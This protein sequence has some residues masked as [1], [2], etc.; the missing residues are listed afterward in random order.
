MISP[1]HPDVAW[2]C[3]SYSRFQPRQIVRI[4][5]SFIG[6][7]ILSSSAS[8]PLLPVNERVTTAGG[9]E[10]MVVN[11][12]SPSSPPRTAKFG[13][14]SV[15]FGGDS[16]QR[17]S[18]PHTPNV[19]AVHGG[20]DGAEDSPVGRAR[21][22]GGPS[23]DSDSEDGAPVRASSSSPQGQSRRGVYCAS[24]AV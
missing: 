23:S 10:V 19:V 6:P 14:R 1:A 15:T 2:P 3:A 11:P 21:R 22:A 7:G 5:N 17:A 18:V 20:F 16:E 13:R 24:A 12:G 8:A 9:A 4:D